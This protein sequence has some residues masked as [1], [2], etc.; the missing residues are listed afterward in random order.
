MIETTSGS[1]IIPS[2]IRTNGAVEICNSEYDY[3]G[4]GGTPNDCYGGSLQV[5]TSKPLKSVHILGNGANSFVNENNFPSN[6]DAVILEGDNSYPVWMTVVTNNYGSGATNGNGLDLMG[7]DTSDPVN[8]YDHWVVATQGYLNKFTIGHTGGSGASN[9]HD[10]VS[11]PYF[12]M[13]TSGNSQ[14][15]GN[16]YITGSLTNAGGSDPP[17]ELYFNETREDVL[18]KVRMNVPQERANGLVT[19]YNKENDRMEFFKPSDCKFYIQTVNKDTFEMQLTEDE[20]IKDGKPCYN[21]NVTIEYYWDST[22]GVIKTKQ[23]IVKPF[24]P[25][26]KDKEINQTSGKLQLTKEAVDIATAKEKARLDALKK[27]SNQT[28]GGTNATKV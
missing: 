6:H 27:V 23:S 20:T 8:N 21:S 4:S 12:T 3:Y 5:G 13:D 25:M 1:G 17:Y 19:F 24:I 22:V 9:P 11:S 18:A 28:L 16:V 26:P 10:A 14:F 2:A 7:I 15:N